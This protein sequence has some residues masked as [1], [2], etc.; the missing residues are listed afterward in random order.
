MVSVLRKIFPWP[1]FLRLDFEEKKFCRRPLYGG[2]YFPPAGRWSIRGGAK[3]RRVR[4]HSPRRA[5]SPTSRTGCGK[6]LAAPLTTR[7]PARC[8]LTWR[9]IHRRAPLQCH[10]HSTRLR[11]GAAIEHPT[12]VSLG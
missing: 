7:G 10:E 8:S 5:C 1:V 2:R 11:F 3:T 4:P 12:V 6:W 9:T